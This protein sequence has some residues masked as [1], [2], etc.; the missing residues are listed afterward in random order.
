MR[1]SYSPGFQVNVIVMFDR[2]QVSSLFHFIRIK[3]E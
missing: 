3:I 1:A 2:K